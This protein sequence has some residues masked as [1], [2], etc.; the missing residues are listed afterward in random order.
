MIES[1]VNLFTIFQI[2]L[3]Y[4]FVLVIGLYFKL[5]YR[6]YVLER[7]KENYIACNYATGN[8]CNDNLILRVV[9]K[10]LVLLRRK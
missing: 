4:K 10:M 9:S 8:I 7:Q 5:E 2:L 1:I 3:N 6:D